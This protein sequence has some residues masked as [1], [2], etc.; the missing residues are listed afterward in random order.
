MEKNQIILE[1]KSHINKN[2][3]TY[4]NWYVGIAED[5][6]ERLFSG[7]NVDKDNDIWIYRE[8]NSSE[9]AREIEEYFLD[10]G[11]KGGSGGGDS[12]AKYVYAYKINSHTKE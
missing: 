5:P 11:T 9:V 7:H 2:G 1:I 6:E 8:S 12:D 4:Q 3:A 10:L